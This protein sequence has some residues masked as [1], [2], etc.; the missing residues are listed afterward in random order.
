MELIKNTLNNKQEYN[1]DA[2]NN[3]KDINGGDADPANF[4][5]HGVT[6]FDRHRY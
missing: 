2:Q 4:N 1:K 5:Q 6:V 3:T